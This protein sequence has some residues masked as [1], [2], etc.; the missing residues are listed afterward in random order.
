MCGMEKDFNRNFNLKIKI[1]INFKTLSNLC[2]NLAFPIVSLSGSRT[3]LTAQTPFVAQRILVGE[4]RGKKKLWP[5][6][7][8][9]QTSISIRRNII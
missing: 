2:P 3:Y 6:H 7:E 9:E 8:S 4:V 5:T 1:K